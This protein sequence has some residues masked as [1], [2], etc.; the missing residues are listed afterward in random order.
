MKGAVEQKRRL[1]KWTKDFF[2]VLLVRGFIC[3]VFQDHRYSRVS[4][5]PPWDHDVRENSRQA[6]C[7]KE[8]GF[9]GFILLNPNMAWITH[10]SGPGTANYSCQ[11]ET[12]RKLE[13]KK[14]RDMTVSP[15]SYIYKHQVT[16]LV[17]QNLMVY[18]KF[19][20]KVLF[21]CQI[22]SWFAV[23]LFIIFVDGP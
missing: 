6:K 22:D 19:H 15:T 17:F 9:Q 1:I 11:D 13:V 3:F 12:I 16:H 18:S 8:A 7:Y 2:T 14:L 23:S 5:Q 20:P 10:W 21:C 4:S